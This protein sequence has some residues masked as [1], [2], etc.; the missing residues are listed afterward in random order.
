MH[1]PRLAPNTELIE[2]MRLNRHGQILLL[3]LHLERLAHSALHFGF[4]FNK[5][6]VLRALAP[7]LHQC[8]PQAQRLRLS[9]ASNGALTIQCSPLLVTPQPVWVVLAPRPIQTEARYLCHKTTVRSH[10]A[11]GEKWLQQHPAYFDVIYYDDQGFITEG[12]R[13]SVYVQQHS[14]WFTP[15]YTQ[16]LLPGVQRAALLQQ[17]LVQEKHLTVTDLLAAPQLRVSNALRG[18]LDA[19]LKV[20]NGFS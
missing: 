7:Y 14:Q 10:W 20:I 11:T 17:G 5:A 1:L 16:A 3:D 4:A 6:A 8:Y 2:T 19:R 15:P 12:G 9:L 13:S 18:W